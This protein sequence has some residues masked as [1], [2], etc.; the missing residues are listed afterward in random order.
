MDKRIPADKD[1]VQPPAS[2]DG[3]VAAACVGDGN[4]DSGGGHHE[5]DE[6]DELLTALGRT[7]DEDVRIATHEAGHAVCA[8]LLGHPLG[9]ATVDPACVARR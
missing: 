4:A 2:V 3:T 9:G 8:R 7:E 1:T 5:V 6:Y